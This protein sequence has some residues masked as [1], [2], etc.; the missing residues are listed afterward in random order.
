ML[1]ISVAVCEV[2]LV[3]VIRGINEDVKSCSAKL[4]AYSLDSDQC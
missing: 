1:S 2:I 3:C 4:L